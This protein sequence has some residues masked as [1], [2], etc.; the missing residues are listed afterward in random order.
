[1]V[2]IVEEGGDV[3]VLGRTG[4]PEARTTGD[5]RLLANGAQRVVAA[6]EEYA[7]NRYLRRLTFESP[8]LGI[9]LDVA[10]GVELNAARNDCTPAD[11]AAMER[12]PANLGGGQWR[13]PRGALYRVRIRN[14][15]ARRAFVYLVDLRPGGQVEVL[16]PA[17]GR[18]GEQLEPGAQVDQCFRLS[19]D[20]VGQ[21]VL[22]VFA[23]EVQQDLR[24]WFESARPTRGEEPDRAQS[25]EVIIDIQPNQE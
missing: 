1:M 24:G 12:H 5:D 18:T 22:K 2:E 20:D 3:V 9:E 19:A 8:E 13:L 21:E 23:T 10:P 16:R 6:V 11:W 14:T 4:G 15:G 7:R 17:S 25:R